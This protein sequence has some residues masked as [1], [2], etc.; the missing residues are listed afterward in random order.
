MGQHGGFDGGV[1]LQKSTTSWRSHSI[2][3]TPRRLVPEGLVDGA[4]DRSL[5]ARRRRGETAGMTPR[6]RVR[7]HRHHR[8]RAHDHADRTRAGDPQGSRQRRPGHRRHRPVRDQRSLRRGGVRVDPR[9]RPR[10]RGGQRQ[11]RRHRPRPPAGRHRRHAA[12]DRARRA[13]ARELPPRAWSPS[14]SAAA[15]ASPP[16]SSACSAPTTATPNQEP[17]PR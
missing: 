10:P 3:S 13:G 11:R 8:Q 1:A 4:G 12:R 2:T 6:A 7:G 16:S 15:W 9:A 14:A 5:S 17:H